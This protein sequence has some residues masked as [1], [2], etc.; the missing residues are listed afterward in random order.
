LSINPT[1]LPGPSVRVMTLPKA[2]L[3]D[4]Q[5]TAALQQNH[6]AFTV[7]CL[8]DRTCLPAPVRI[9]RPESVHV[10]VADVDDLGVWLRELGGEVHVSPA[11]EGVELWTLHTS[12]EP[13]ADGVRVLVSVPVPVGELVMDWIRAAVR[14]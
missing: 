8:I 5:K 13:D 4:A 10:M 2:P 9:P 6:N 12:T 14:R 3:P 11:F 1:G 7:D